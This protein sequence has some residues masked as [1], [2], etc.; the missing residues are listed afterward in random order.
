MRKLIIINASNIKEGG[1]LSYLNWFFY[2]KNFFNQKLKFVVRR[3]IKIKK[4]NDI[5]IVE[6]SPA[7]SIKVRKQISHYINNNNPSLV[8]TLFGPSYLNIS[9]KHLMGVGDGWVYFWSLK[10]LLKVYK[11]NILDMIKKIFEIFYKSLHF[12]KANFIFCESN[13]LKKKIVENGNFSND[14]IFVIKNLDKEKIK[15]KKKQK[16]YKSYFN[17][18]YINILYL[19]DYRI[20]KN[21][22]YLASLINFY[23]S[24]YRKKVRLI[25]TMKK[26]DLK[27]SNLNKALNKNYFIN[28]DNIKYED[29]PN[30][31]KQ[32]DFVVLPSLIETYSSNVVESLKANKIILLSNIPQHK[33]E[34][35]DSFKY[36]DLN[37]IKKSSILIN[38][39]ITDKFFQQK[40]IKKQKRFFK[41]NAVERQREFQD[42]FNK[43][44]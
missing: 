31:Y 21:F 27:G 39:I 42:L 3:E 22:E 30:I 18:K 15:N 6:K 4:N 44:T 20:H 17:K 5:L 1:A 11:K 38:K 8:F 41:I 32:C 12:K 37:S 28:L 23:N 35:K 34:F 16:N 25:L 29:L 36:L 7:K 9:H 26:N 14:N 13:F 43:L 19:T 40:I 33:Y 2:N 10:L 24:N